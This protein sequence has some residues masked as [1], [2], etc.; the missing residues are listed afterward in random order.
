VLHV[1]GKDPAV[2]WDEVLE[3]DK[4]FKKKHE[5]FYVSKKTFDN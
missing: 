3:R 2:G 4:V 5:G 1:L